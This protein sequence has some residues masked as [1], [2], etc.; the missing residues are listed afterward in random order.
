MFFVIKLHVGLQGKQLH[1]KQNS[2]VLPGKLMGTTR[3]HFSASNAKKCK[4]FFPEFV[5][6]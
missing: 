2:K 1:K 3:L 6:T 5:F 4:Q